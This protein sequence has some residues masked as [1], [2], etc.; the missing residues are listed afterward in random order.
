MPEFQHQ[1]L[2]ISIRLQTLQ[3]RL[4]GVWCLCC[5]ARTVR[6]CKAEGGRKKPV[7]GRRNVTGLKLTVS[8]VSAMHLSVA[9]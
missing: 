8:V 7:D 5:F 4:E 2:L 9:D 3:K 1:N 6:D